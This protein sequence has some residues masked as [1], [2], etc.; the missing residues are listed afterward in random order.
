[1]SRLHVRY[2][3][4]RITYHRTSGGWIATAVCN[5]LTLTAHAES[6]DE[7]WW[8]IVNQISACL[9]GGGHG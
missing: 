4:V 9:E 3:G 1:M 8:L 5:G 2:K 7:A 6:Q